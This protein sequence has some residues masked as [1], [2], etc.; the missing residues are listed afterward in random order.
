MIWVG[1]MGGSSYVNVMYYVLED[2]Q[3]QKTEKELALTITAI[4][5]DVGI[6]LSS[7]LTL[8]LDNTAFRKML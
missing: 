2:E 3:L 6:L 1:L 4:C 5:D 7:S 8:L